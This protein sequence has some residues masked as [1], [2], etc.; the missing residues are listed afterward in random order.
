MSE[1]ALC[2]TELPTVL[3]NIILDWLHSEQIWYLHLDE[4]SGKFSYRHNVRNHVRMIMG[5][6]INPIFAFTETRCLYWMEHSKPISLI[7]HGETI[8]AIEHCLKQHV[9]NSRFNDNT[10]TDLYIKYEYNGQPEYL[11]CSGVCYG[12]DDTNPQLF[13]S[14]VLYRFDSS[15]GQYFAKNVNITHDTNWFDYTRR[16]CIETISVDY[17]HECKALSDKYIQM[18]E[19]DR[20]AKKTILA[21]MHFDLEIEKKLDTAM[22]LIDQSYNP[23]LDIYEPALTNATI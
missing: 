18:R 2:F 19:T 6:H 4:T 3:V 23:H 13:Y 16:V 14:G 20:S 11:K 9:P 21:E 7:I 15:R 8:P 22:E 10:Y 17:L 12:N 1:L 5:N